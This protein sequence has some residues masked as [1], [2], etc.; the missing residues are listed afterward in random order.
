MIACLERLD[1]LLPDFTRIAWASDRARQVWEPR[2]TRINE[3]WLR[4]EWLSVAS[5]LRSCGLTVASPDTY[6]VWAGEWI[7]RGL[8]ALPLEIQAIPGGN[9]ESRAEKS[10]VFRFLIATAPNVAR[11][12]RALDTGDHP[13]IAKLLGCPP[14]CHAFFH[15][16]W[17]DHGLTDTTWSAAWATATP[18]A[19]TRSI[20]IAGSPQ[21]NVLWRWIGMR[22]VPHLPC[23]FDCEPTVALGKDF[24]TLGRQTG[25]E[26][27]MDWLFEIL[28]W[29]LEWSALHGIAEIRTPLLRIS[30]R[31]DATGPKYS[32]R[33]L[34][35][36]YPEEGAQGL[37]FPY[38]N[39]PRHH[40]VALGSARRTHSMEETS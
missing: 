3:A 35:S 24:E 39:P 23:R 20:E 36:T 40:L 4:L 7:E 22:A 12:R 19:G 6:L 14:C 17:V 25:Y 37:G 30:T 11:F 26:Q 32:V 31:T 29:P 16:I 27:E 13:E 38:R 10:F 33:W 34:G 1:F 8:S 5:G 9:P 28:S 21:A 15:E 2:I 18:S